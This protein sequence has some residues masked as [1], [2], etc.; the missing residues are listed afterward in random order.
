MEPEYSN[1]QPKSRRPDADYDA[2]LICQKG[3][4]SLSRLMQKLIDHKCTVLLCV[5]TNRKDDISLTLQN[6]VEPHSEFLKKNPVSL[7]QY[8]SKYINHETVDQRKSK[9]TKQEDTLLQM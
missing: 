5:I 4:D 8:R 2:C 9:F 6:E 7:A 3:A 1:K